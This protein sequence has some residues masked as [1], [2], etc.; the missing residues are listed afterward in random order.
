VAGRGLQKRLLGSQRLTKPLLQEHFRQRQ[1]LGAQ[2]STLPRFNGPLL[3]AKLGTTNACAMV[4][5][6][7]CA[8][9]RMLEAT[10][11]PASTISSF[12]R[13]AKEADMAGRSV[14]LQAW[15]CMLWRE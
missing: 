8:A 1:P 2:A 13:T 10:G 3:R 14:P 7:G 4:N 9:K 5:W 15:F 6:N 12:L 11:R